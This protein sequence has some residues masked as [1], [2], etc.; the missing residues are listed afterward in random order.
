MLPVPALA[1]C[2][3]GSV[4]V[5]ALV[6]TGTGIRK[7]STNNGN[8]HI[9]VPTTIPLLEDYNTKTTSC[10]LILNSNL[11]LSNNNP[12]TNTSWTS[13]PN[14][15][16]ALWH[17]YGYR[18]R[19]R[20]CLIWSNCSGLSP[21]PSCRC[22]WHLPYPE[23]KSKDSFLVT[24]HSEITLIVAR[25]RFAYYKRN[26]CKWHLHHPDCQPKTYSQ[27]PPIHN[28]H[29]LSPLQDIH[30]A[31]LTTQFWAGL[32]SWQTGHVLV[33]NLHGWRPMF[34]TCL[35]RWA[36]NV[37]SFVCSGPWA[38]LISEY[39][40]SKYVSLLTVS[41]STFLSTPAYQ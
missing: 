16:F 30:P 6:I 38:L 23:L 29:S 8:L 9:F 22:K 33:N 37:H 10:D 12:S 1:F 21:M 41:T 15:H 20:F 27:L 7:S 18:K 3:F 5:L 19:Y 34:S 25:A 13:C 32:L 28:S 4:S 36:D 40:A 31:N 24:S 11:I 14:H 35:I 39:A 26:N 17:C 2:Y